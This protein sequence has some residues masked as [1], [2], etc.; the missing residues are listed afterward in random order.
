[1]TLK[2]RTQMSVSDIA[3]LAVLSLLWGGSF[4]FVEVLVNYLPPLTIVTAR[5]GL[6]AMLLW[7]IVLATGVQRPTERKD[8]LSLLVVGGLNNALPFSLIVW[9]QTQIDSGLA[10]VLNATTPLFT[11]VVASVF[12]ADERLTKNKLAGVMIGLV[13]ICVLVGPNAFRGLGQSVLGQLA[14]VGAAMSYALAGVFSRRF[15]ARGIP[16]LM[17]ATGQVS[18][19]TLLLL[20]PVI[21]IDGAAI[22]TPLP[23]TAWGALIGIALFSTVLAYILYFRLI[24]SAGATNA[25]LVTFLIPL[26]AIAL[27]A[28]FLGE[29]FT[30]I[31]A[32]GAALIG[33]GLVVMDGRVFNRA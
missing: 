5:V 7:V 24:A 14:V 11:V 2:I 3:I 17:I 13:R 12:L 6:A 30:P 29:R 18:S 1:M 9:G 15:A 21:L 22:M 23:I 10:S 31:Q 27:G 4:F 32:A 8:W 19:A 25:A 26:S 33:V 16:P 28:I 20:I